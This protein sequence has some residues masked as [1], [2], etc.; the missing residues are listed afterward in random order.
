MGMKC[1]KPWT[2]AEEDIL[3]EHYPVLG[4][5]GVVKAGLLPGRTPSSI[6]NKVQGMGLSA[7]HLRYGA[8]KFLSAGW[9]VPAQD[10]A[11][12]HRDWQ[13]VRVPVSPNLGYTSLRPSL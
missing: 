10:F 3:A 9:C 13:S 12:A 5:A 8:G 11:D 6:K 1:D 4:K 2:P 7:A